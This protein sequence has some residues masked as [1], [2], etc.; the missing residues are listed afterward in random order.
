MLT[1]H[2]AMYHVT[3]TTLP[4]TRDTA[5]LTMP[6]ASSRH[7][8]ARGSWHPSVS[9]RRHGW[10]GTGWLCSSYLDSGR[11]SMSIS[12]HGSASTWGVGPWGSIT[13]E[14]G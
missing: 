3:S 11:E 7:G 9:P 1:T 2:L 14:A 10:W 4:P 12:G 13:V 8:A 5:S 6:S